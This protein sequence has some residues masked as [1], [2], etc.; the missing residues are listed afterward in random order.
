MCPS[1]PDNSTLAKFPKH[2]TAACAEL[3]VDVIG[4][5]TPHPVKHVRRFFLSAPKT[6]ADS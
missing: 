1:I 5:G 4:K 6:F 3:A 2:S